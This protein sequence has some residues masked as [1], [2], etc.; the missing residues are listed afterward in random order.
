MEISVT[1]KPISLIEISVQLSVGL[2]IGW[3]YRLA[4]ASP[5]ELLISAFNAEVIFESD[6]P[7]PELDIQ[8][9]HARLWN[10]GIRHSR[11]RPAS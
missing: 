8:A 4:K 7:E 11:E 2:F 9:E 6:A 3:I 10:E 1:D 5:S